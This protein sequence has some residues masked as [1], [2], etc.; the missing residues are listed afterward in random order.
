MNLLAYPAAWRQQHFRIIPQDSVHSL[1][2]VQRQRRVDLGIVLH[3]VQC[4]VRVELKNA[5]H[6][7][8]HDFTRDLV[9]ME[10]IGHNPVLHLLPTLA[11][12]NG[13]QTPL[14]VLLLRF[15]P[16]LDALFPDRVFGGKFLHVFVELLLG[17]FCRLLV[18]VVQ[19]LFQ[20][21][22]NLVSELVP[23]VC[24]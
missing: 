7:I 15:K 21:R 19:T 16:R 2:V 20:V 23:L 17:S 3:L 13:L 24:H 11:G 12:S 5:R 4:E 10:L 22:Q 1:A 9:Y 8:V 6:F 14:V 18:L